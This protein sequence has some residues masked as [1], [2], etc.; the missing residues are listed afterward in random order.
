MGLYNIAWAFTWPY[1]LSIQA[2]IDHT[3]TV[4]VAGQFSNL[5][6]NAIGPAMAAFCVGGGEYVPAVWLACAL[7]VASLLPM[8]ASFRTK[9]LKATA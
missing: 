1:F 2:D 4:V 3:G 8:L 6:G 7:F 9:V 5:V